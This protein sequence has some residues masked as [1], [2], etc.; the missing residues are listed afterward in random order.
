MHLDIYRPKARTDLY[1]FVPAG[2]NPKI[3]FAEIIAQ[4]GELDFIKSREV[5]PGQK[6][7]G[8][9]ADEILQNISRVGFH[10][11][12]VNVSTQVSEG[13]AALGGGI[14]GASIGGPFGAIIGAA[15]GYAF[16]EHAKKVSDEL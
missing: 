7:I 11:Q 3:H 12:G 14:L 8:A 9:S 16:A 4:S 15:L 2:I 10:I 5:L 1:F 13:G 6:L